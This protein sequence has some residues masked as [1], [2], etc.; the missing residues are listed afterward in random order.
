MNTAFL[1]EGN[2]GGPDLDPADVPVFETFADISA[3]FSPKKQE[4]SESFRR[5]RMPYQHQIVHHL[6][7]HSDKP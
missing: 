2:E 1:S 6:I 3:Y 4:I 7:R 5:L